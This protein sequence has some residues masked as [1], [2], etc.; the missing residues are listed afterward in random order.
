MNFVN[1]AEEFQ[2]YPLVFAEIPDYDFSRA[3]QNGMIPRHYMVKDARLRLKNYVNLYLKE[4]ALV[5]NIDTFE[6]FLEVAA[7]TNTEILNYDN[8]ASDCGG[9]YIEISSTEYAVES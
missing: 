9:L 6:R 2:Q 8:V 4:E 5:Q 1:A 7:V 3:I